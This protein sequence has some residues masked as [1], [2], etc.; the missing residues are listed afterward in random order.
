MKKIIIDTDIGSDID[1]IWAVVLMLS[2]NLFDV[3]MI[4]VTQGDIEYQVKLV[5][6]ILQM[7]NKTH[8]P[9]ARGLTNHLQDIIYPQKRWLEDFD[10]DTYEGKIYD[11]YQEAYEEVLTLDREVTLVGLASFTSLATV[12]PTLKKHNI[13]VVAM[14]GSINIGYFNRKTPDPECN[15]VSDIEAAKKFLTSGLD[16]TLFPLDVC[17][18]LL[19]TKKDY[20][21]IR[22]GVTPH[23]KVICENY[24]IWQE[25]YIGGAKKFDIENSSSI[26]YDLAPVLYLLFPQ[27]FDV[28]EKDVYVDDRGYTLIGGV[29][30]MN[31]AL[32]VHKLNA[33][34]SFVSEQYCTMFAVDK[35]IR[36]LEVE[37]RYAL[38]FTL[39]KCNVMLS[40]VEYGWEKK[41]PGSAYGPSERDYYILHFVTN[42]KGKLKVGDFTFEIDKGDCFLLPPKL[43]TFYE[44]DKKDPYE[45]YWVGFDGI[46]A[47]ELLKKAGLIINNNFVI[48][49]KDYHKVLKRFI[50]VKVTTG[51]KYVAPYQLVGSLY[52][53][54]SELIDEDNI[55][56]EEM[57]D[58]VDLAINYMN[59]NYDKDITVDTVSK[60]IGIERTYFYRLFKETTKI[61]PKEYLTN[62][63]LEKAK[64]LLCNT[65]MSISE[66]ATAV[67][68]S[69]YASF[70]KIFKVKYGDIPKTYRIKNT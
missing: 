70:V 55:H 19:I 3:K 68:Y 5:A 12:V 15:I 34:L 2:T 49:P 61:S 24:D 50:D 16:I 38:T 40:V 7:L 62:L 22:A 63:R 17:N 25:D 6:K 14:A 43:T 45:Y 52:L 56:E 4:S 27:H 23:C 57:K 35:D 58:Y 65:T 1:D 46:E 44:A 47:K 13:K 39:K 41:S 30:K 21:T 66:V 9:I 42:G 20:K 26:L 51:M 54:L 32:N 59:T 53:L 37:G 29:H 60:V 31:I 18:N 33:M 64:V 8:I 36:Q 10:L 67:G 48:K 11:T 28:I 69:N